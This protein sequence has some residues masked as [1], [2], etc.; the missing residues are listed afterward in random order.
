MSWSP[1]F[2][3]AAIIVMT[4]AIVLAMTLRPAIEIRADHLSIGKR[5]VA[6]A[7]VRRAFA[8]TQAGRRHVNY[9]VGSFVWVPE[10]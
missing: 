8:C 9:R 6:W 1:A 7:D 5:S 3:P 10:D 4:A 2:V